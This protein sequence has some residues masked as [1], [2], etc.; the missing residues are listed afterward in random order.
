MFDLTWVG[1]NPN[2]VEL[3]RREDE[4]AAANLVVVAEGASTFEVDILRI[5]RVSIKRTHAA[6]VIRVRRMK[7]RPNV[8][9]K[10]MPKKTRFRGEGTG[11]RGLPSVQQMELAQPSFVRVAATMARRAIGMTGPSVAPA[12]TPIL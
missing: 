6:I 9:L 1:V 4:G 5:K 8:C 11:T 7:P 10:L 3:P 12:I 2:Q